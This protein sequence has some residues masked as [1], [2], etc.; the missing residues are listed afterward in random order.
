MVQTQNQSRQNSEAEPD[1]MATSNLQTENDNTV[2]DA[3]GG[4]DTLDRDSPG[5]TAANIDEEI[6]QVLQERDRLLKQQ[7]L[8]TLC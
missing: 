3:P 6:A 4:D 8:E 5:R 2:D 1:K 7:Q